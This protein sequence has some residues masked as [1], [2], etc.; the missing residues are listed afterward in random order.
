MADNPNDLRQKAGIR[1][2]TSSGIYL[3]ECSSDGTGS[4]ITWNIWPY[5][6]AA[7]FDKEVDR[8]ELKDCENALVKTDETL[9]DFKISGDILQ[10]DYTLEK[11]LDDALG[12]YWNVIR[13]FGTVNGKTKFRVFPICEISAVRSID[14]SDFNKF[15][16]TISSLKNSTAVTVYV[17][18]AITDI[19]SAGSYVVAAAAQSLL[20]ECL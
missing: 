19:I 6:N 16:F 8:A 10:V 18:D 17:T 12:K 4:S 14:E 5:W 13:N 1:R 11:F 9:T 3:R 15:N 20:T 7:K 2:F